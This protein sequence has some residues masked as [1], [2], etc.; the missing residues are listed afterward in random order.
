MLPVFCLCVDC[1]S[2]IG[3]VLWPSRYDEES[4]RYRCAVR[5]PGFLHPHRGLRDDG[6][7]PPLYLRDMDNIA[8]MTRGFGSVL[9]DRGLFDGV[10]PHRNHDCVA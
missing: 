7:T 6:R 3:Y 5:R 8:E 9:V 4:G 2:Y 1:W 10:A